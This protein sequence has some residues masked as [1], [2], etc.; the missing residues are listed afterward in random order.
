MLF[1]FEINEGL[2][3]SLELS[4]RSFLINAHETAIRLMALAQ[5]RANP[6]PS[7]IIGRST[8]F[9]VSKESR[10]VRVSAP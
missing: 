1:D 10:Q 2:S 9:H 6:L 8:K 3:D 7:S 4:K 5:L